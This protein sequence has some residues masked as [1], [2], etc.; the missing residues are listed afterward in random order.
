[1]VGIYDVNLF[2][3]SFTSAHVFAVSKNLGR[4]IRALAVTVSSIAGRLRITRNRRMRCD[5]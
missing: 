1:M 5:A 3:E 2:V 4:G